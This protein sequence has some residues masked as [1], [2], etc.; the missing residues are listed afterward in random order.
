VNSFLARILTLKENRMCLAYN[1]EIYV[2]RS[3]F[4]TTYVWKLV[5]IFVT[6]EVYAL[7]FRDCFN[8][9]NVN[10]GHYAPS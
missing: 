6:Y 2:S 4:M 3:V 9:M 7:D 8:N 5:D 10:T 1:L